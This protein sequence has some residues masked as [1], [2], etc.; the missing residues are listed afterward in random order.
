M[1]K[2][3]ILFFADELRK[4]SLTEEQ[5]AVLQEVLFPAWDN[6]PKSLTEAAMDMARAYERW[7]IEQE[8]MPKPTEKV[9]PMSNEEIEAL[10]SMM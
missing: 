2:N 3:L 1:E 4:R 9:K 7:S 6:T 5:S 8:K 10:A